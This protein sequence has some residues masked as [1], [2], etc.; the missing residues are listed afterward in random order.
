MA[1]VASTEFG[2]SEDNGKN[3]KR[4]DA[5][6]KA[7]QVLLVRGNETYDFA[8]PVEPLKSDV[9]ETVGTGVDVTNA[10]QVLENQFLIHHLLA[11]QND[12]AKLLAQERTKEEL[13]F[14]TRKPVARIK[15]DGRSRN[16]WNPIGLRILHSRQAREF[17]DDSAAVLQS[18]C[19]QGPAVVRTRANDVQFVAS[20]RAMFG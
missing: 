4:G 5:E 17:R 12:A 14:P 1:P 19:D 16:R 20:H 15:F 9:D 10:P 6:D 2:L 7:K 3:P 11:V 18:M 13:V 8:E